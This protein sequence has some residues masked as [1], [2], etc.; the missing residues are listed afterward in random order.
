MEHTAGP[1]VVLRWNKLE[2]DWRR[3]YLAGDTVCFGQHAQ[4]L[5]AAH[6]T[7]AND[8]LLANLQ[9]SRAVSFVTIWYFNIQHTYTRQA[10]VWLTPVHSLVSVASRMRCGA[11]YGVVLVGTI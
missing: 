5:A 4:I 9:H 2:Q 1:S 3:L 8:V 11:A 7:A 10:G 6:R